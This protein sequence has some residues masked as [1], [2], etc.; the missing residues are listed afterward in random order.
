MLLRLVLWNP[1]R[2]MIPAVIELRTTYTLR[3]TCGDLDMLPVTRV[4]WTTYM[5]LLRSRRIAL[6][7]HTNADSSRPDRSD[8]VDLLSPCLKQV[9][10]PLRYFNW[11]SNCVTGAILS[12]AGR[13]GFVTW[14]SGPS[15]NSSA[16]PMGVLHAV[17][18]GATPWR[19]CCLGTGNG[20][21]LGAY[22]VCRWVEE[23]VQ[24]DRGCEEGWGAKGGRR[25]P[26]AEGLASILRTANKVET[27]APELQHSAIPA[28][29]GSSGL[30]TLDVTSML[31]SVIEA[32]H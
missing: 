25:E 10:R 12:I 11:V 7:V 1:V 27:I 28:S 30:Q 32:H 3:Q 13:L 26:G 22:S 9:T 8:L 16:T 20:A 5:P 19:R 4:L 14:Q 24:K 29:L 17:H 15:V 18:A 31:A 23:D 2:P 21:V 6:F